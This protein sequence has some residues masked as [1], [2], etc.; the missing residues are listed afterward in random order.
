MTRDEYERRRQHLD[1]E[2]KA[3]IEALETA[4]R[5]QVR[6]L[7]LTWMMLSQESVA[8]APPP[9]RKPAA[10]VREP[11]AALTAQPK[12]EHLPEDLLAVVARCPDVF[13]RNDVCRELG[14]KPDRSALYRALQSLVQDGS[15]TVL[16]R[17]EG[18]APTRYAKRRSA[19]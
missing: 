7:D 9:T 17:G 10:G 13:D 5:L 3:G 14:F 16:E 18:R 15:L 8:P 6:A 1:R 4:H 12:D 19:P 2:L 11:A